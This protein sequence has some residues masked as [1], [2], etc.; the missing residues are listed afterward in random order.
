MLN[1]SPLFPI[2][3]KCVVL[4]YLGVCTEIL[5]LLATLVQL[6]HKREELLAI[7]RRLNIKVE[8]V[9]EFALGNLTALQ[10]YEVHTR[11]VE[12]RHYTEE[13]TGTVG[14]EHHYTCCHL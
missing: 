13:C 11:R 10:L 4:N 1:N 6:A 2:Y 3:K 8:T 14:N 12:T 9:F 5:E 7:H